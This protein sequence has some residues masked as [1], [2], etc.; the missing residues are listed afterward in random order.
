[1]QKEEGF[2]IGHF[3]TLGRASHFHPSVVGVDWAAFW[4]KLVFDVE[5]VGSLGFEPFLASAF[6]TPSAGQGLQQ[7]WYVLC[8]GFWR[9]LASAFGTPSAG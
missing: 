6:G 5:D 7:L 8:P 9:I 1:M 3:R 2:E 4:A